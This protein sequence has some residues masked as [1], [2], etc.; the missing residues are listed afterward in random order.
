[1]TLTHEKTKT[2]LYS[3]GNGA[4]DSKFR[5]GIGGTDEDYRSEWNSYIKPKTETKKEPKKET[6]KQR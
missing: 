5:F 4:P 1:M 6:K 3:E 2:S